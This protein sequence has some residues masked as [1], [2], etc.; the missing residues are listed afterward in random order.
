[1]CDHGEAT[2]PP[3]LFGWQ[4]FAELMALHGDRGAKAVAANHQPVLVA[5]ADAAWDID[6]PEAWER[7]LAAVD[8]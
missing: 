3:A 6:S 4:H 8:A 2:G 1:M 5:F 7:F